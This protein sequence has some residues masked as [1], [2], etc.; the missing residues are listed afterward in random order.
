MEA[1][2]AVVAAI[3]TFAEG[4]ADGLPIPTR[5]LAHLALRVADLER[6]RDFYREVFGMRVVW[7]PDP[8]NVY[9]STGRDNLALHRSSAAAPA[10]SGALDHL[11]FLVE[12]AEAVF[13]AAAALE[14]R[15]VALLK[16]PRHH[17]DG[18]SSFYVED[19]EG[20]VVQ[21]LYTPDAS[22]A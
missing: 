22:A 8:D 18:S 1:P 17:R 10:E 3:E 13:A 21:V 15:G 11:G 6:M 5:G 9:L 7:Q 16:P 12:S 4:M 14:R 20:N 19:P 2:E